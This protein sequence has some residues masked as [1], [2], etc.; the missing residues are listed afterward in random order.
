MC[1]SICIIM[2]Q[3]ICVR[4]SIDYSTKAY[5]LQRKKKKFN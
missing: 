4:Y 3:N 1:V 2:N 5:A